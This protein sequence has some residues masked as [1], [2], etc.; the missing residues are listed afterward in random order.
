M[1]ITNFIVSDSII[2]YFSLYFHNSFIGYFGISHHKPWSHSLPSY[3][4]SSPSMLPPSKKN[5]RE[6]KKIK[7]RTNFCC[8]YTQWSIVNLQEFSFS[9][10]KFMLSCLFL[11]SLVRWLDF[12]E[13]K[14]SIIKLC[15]TTDARSWHHLKKHKS[16]ILILL[17][18]QLREFLSK[19]LYLI[20]IE[21]LMLNRNCYPHFIRKKVKI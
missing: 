9:F 3:P 7:N 8:I 10:F 1:S 18:L 17:V 13:T 11:C 16:P 20:C 15:N 21:L 19:L 4:W 5:K 14:Q 2:I 12:S 6:K